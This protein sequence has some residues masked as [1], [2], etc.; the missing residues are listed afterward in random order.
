MESKRF[1]LNKEEALS[2]AKVAGWTIA[3]ALVALGI[4]LVNLIEIPVEY[5]F[6][7]P[8]INTVLYALKEFIQGQ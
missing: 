1:R 2:V 3:A 4:D 5:A 6:I 7:V 8:I